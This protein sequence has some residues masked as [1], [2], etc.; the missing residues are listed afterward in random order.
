[1]CNFGRGQYLIH[2]CEM[3]LNLDNWFRTS[4]FL[5]IFYLLLY[6]LVEGIMGNI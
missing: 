1:M 5:N 2:L 4:C 3:I 6:C